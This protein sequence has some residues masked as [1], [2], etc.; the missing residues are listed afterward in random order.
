ME[1]PTRFRRIPMGRC[2][3]AAVACV[4]GP[5]WALDATL[6]PP[7]RGQGK[8]IHL[9]LN[10]SIL[11]RLE[12]HDSGFQAP[13]VDVSL[14]PAGGAGLGVAVGMRGFSPRPSMVPSGSTAS[15]PRVDFGLTWRHAGAGER[16][17]DVTAWKRMSS[18]EDAYTLVQ[19]RDPVYGARLEMKLSPARKAGF[20]VERGFIG[21][22]LESGARISVKRKDGRPMVYYRSA[23]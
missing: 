10:A 19:M 4:L 5:A 7:E 8:P 21:V 11:P 22:Q 3:A 9:E 16:Q 15:R 23:F 12:S 1:Q 14:L 13:R 18:E 17:I 2:L 20:N 6:L